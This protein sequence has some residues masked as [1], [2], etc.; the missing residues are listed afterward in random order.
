MSTSFVCPCCGYPGLTT[1]PYERLP[2]APYD[3]LG[4]PPY[5]ERFGAASFEACDCCGYE[6]GFDCDAAACGNPRSFRAYRQQWL[7]GGAT[8][9]SSR[10]AKPPGWN[11][12]RQLA[13][14]GLPVP[15][16]G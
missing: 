2:P 1:R 9:F 6:F 7:S 16:P 4:D 13:V 14:A 11:L 12:N 8:W 5:I 10:R 15:D 3:D